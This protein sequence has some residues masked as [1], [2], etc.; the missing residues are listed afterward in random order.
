MVD[1]R[2]VLTVGETLGADGPRSLE[3]LFPAAYY[4]EQVREAYNLNG[5]WTNAAVPPLNEPVMAA[6]AARL[7]AVGAGPF[8]RRR[9]ARRILEHLARTP[10]GELPLEALENAA[11]LVTAVNGVVR[12]WDAGE[13]AA[14]SPES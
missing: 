10:L 7:A 1:E 13:P 6:A 3:D 9:I 14:Q 8:D 12:G 11:R 5:E 4:D 2:S